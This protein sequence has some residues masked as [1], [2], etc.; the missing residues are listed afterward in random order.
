MFDTILSCTTSNTFSR[1]GLAISYDRDD[2]RLDPK[3]VTLL[4]VIFN[5]IKKF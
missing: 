2:N 4:C 3:S 5:Q 1:K